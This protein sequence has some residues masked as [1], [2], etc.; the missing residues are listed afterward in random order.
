MTSRYYAVLAVICFV[1]A[2]WIASGPLTRMRGTVVAHGDVFGALPPG[3]F[4]GTLMLGGFRGLACDLMWMRAQNA[5]QA[6]RVYESVAMASAIVRVQ[7]H[8]EQ[9]WEFLAYDMAYNIAAETEDPEGKWAWFLAG[10]DVNVQG[11]KR[12]P[13]SDRLLR[14]LAWMFYHKGDMLRERV[15]K[16][17]CSTLLNP[18]FSAL[19][20]LLPPGQTFDPLVPGQQI[21]NYRIAEILYDTSLRLCAA[22][23]RKPP[24]LTRSMVVHAIEHDGNQFRNRGEHST[25]LKR[26]MSALARWDTVIAW[27]KSA[28]L[29][30]D[31]AE[32]HRIHGEIAERNQ[33]R[34]RRK[35]Q[36][37]IEQIIKN[38]TASIASAHIGAGQWSEAERLLANEP[39]TNVVTHKDRIHWLDE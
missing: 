25:A 39:G 14:H 37:L 23:G 6:G 31:D 3:E 29:N 2:Q 30:E 11:L 7:P 4:A 5:Q 21:G 16:H 15:V 27:A 17:D 32:Q 36:I 22:Q 35:T 8:F 34:L 33:G 1:L 13:T 10:I 20:P 24:A 28:P 19:M 38:P 12:N 18:L 26:Y 9:I